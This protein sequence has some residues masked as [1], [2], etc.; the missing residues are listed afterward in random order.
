IENVYQHV[1]KVRDIEDMLIKILE[2]HN[3]RFATLQYG[4][5]FRWGSHFVRIQGTEVAIL[6]DMH[7]AKLVLKT[8]KGEETFILHESHEEDKDREKRNKGSE[9]DGAIMYGKPSQR[10]P[11]WLH[12]MML[13]EMR[14]F[15]NIL[16]G[17]EVD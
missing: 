12:S 15:H 4:S 9:M 8:N 6:I 13:N 17:S 5:A 2:F 11:M 14:Y 10:P 7:N 3:N 16:Q 1:K